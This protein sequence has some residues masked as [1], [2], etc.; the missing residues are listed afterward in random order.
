MSATYS[1]APIPNLD[2]QQIRAVANL[3]RAENACLEL[4]AIGQKAGGDFKARQSLV[5][6]YDDV[7]ALVRD[8][9]R[10]H[11]SKAIYIGLNPRQIEL[12]HAQ[13]ANALTVGEEGGKNADVLYRQWFPIDIDTARPNRRVAATEAEIEAAKP[14]SDA[15]QAELARRG[16]HPILG[17]SG[18]GHHLLVQTIRYT[19]DKTRDGKDG[20]FALLLRWLHR[21]FSNEHAEVDTGVFDPARI[22]KLYGTASIKGGNTVERPWRTAEATPPS[23]SPEPAN[24]LAIFQ[25]EIQEQ[26]ELEAKVKGAGSGEGRER[27]KD[28]TGNLSTLDIVALFKAKDMY[29]REIGNGKHGV[30]CPWSEA[31]SSGQDG[32][33]STVIFESDGTRWP[34]FKC[35]HSH[36]ST[37][38]TKDAFESFDPEL[39]NAHCKEQFRSKKRVSRGP[40]TFTLRPLSELLLEP[41]EETPWLV[42]GLLVKGGTSQLA[43]KPKAGKTTLS[44]Q[45]SLAVAKGEPFLGMP[46]IKGKV[47]Y[48]AVEEK[49]SELVRHFKSMGADP[50]LGDQILVHAASA[51]DECIDQLFDLAMEHKPELIVLDTMLKIIRVKDA[52]AYAEMSAALE[53]LNQLA[54]ETGAH[55]MCLHHMGKAD[56]DGADGV[57]GST[58][59]AGLFDT[60]LM[61]SRKENK[62]TLKSQQRYGTDLEETVL[63]FDLSTGTTHLGPSKREDDTETAAKEILR[64]LADHR[65]P[66][67]EKDIAEIVRGNRSRRL[68]ALRQLHASGRVLRNGKGTR[69]DPHLYGL[70]PNFAGREASGEMV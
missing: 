21:K 26:R 11:G 42:K 19:T 18:N 63:S 56:R 59:I 64:C 65:E 14:V 61:L 28:V 55:V 9:K 32:D 54:R 37:R 27:F 17:K 35:Q 15:I 25:A 20:D 7:D 70:N 57:L 30:R 13:P 24:I 4:R 29:I 60:N 16:I 23:P 69:N 48:I 66:M 22:W 40:K 46:T 41:E 8:A 31:H 58:A 6:F 12:L 34:G 50:G 38:T 43:G 51:P 44:R 10:H 62:R 1:Q 36:C 67:P 33:G 2:E 68:A 45:V 53:P 5:G 47:L 39:L 3:V 49:K 52:N